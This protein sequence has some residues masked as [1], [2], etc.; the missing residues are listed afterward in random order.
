MRHKVRGGCSLYSL[1]IFIVTAVNDASSVVLPIR[2]TKQKRY[3]AERPIRVYAR[4]GSRMVEMVWRDEGR[5][6]RPVLREWRELLKSARPLKFSPAVNYP[7]KEIS[8]GFEALLSTTLF[9]LPDPF[10]PVSL[11]P[12]ASAMDR[13]S[14]ACFSR[15]K[16]LTTGERP[17]F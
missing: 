5:K 17:R 10:R 2:G 11:P 13:S 3:R 16:T 12:T 4:R 9:F 7:K 15:V 1:V 14:C 6:A 8:G